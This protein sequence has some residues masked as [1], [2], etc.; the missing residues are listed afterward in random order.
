MEIKERKQSQG[1]TPYDTVEIAAA[2]VGATALL[3]C[4]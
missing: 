3:I 4:N 2:I 1:G